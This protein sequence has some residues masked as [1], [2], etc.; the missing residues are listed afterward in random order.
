MSLSTVTTVQIT[1]L[2]ESRFR[3][4]A[5]DIFRVKKAA[6]RSFLCKDRRE[7]GSL[8]FTIGNLQKTSENNIKEYEDNKRNLQWFLYNL[9]LQ[10]TGKIYRQSKSRTQ[11]RS[12]TSYSENLIIF[13]GTFWERH[14]WIKLAFK[15]LL[16]RFPALILDCPKTH[17]KKHHLIL[18]R[19]APLPK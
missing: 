6:K 16:R 13:E 4:E 1:K 9:Q 2:N 5:V 18:I 12:F 8:Q 14:L 11:I 7:F 17:P 19:K 15:C 10:R 3:E